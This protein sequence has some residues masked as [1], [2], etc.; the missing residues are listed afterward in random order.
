MG[1]STMGLDIVAVGGDQAQDGLR[2]LLARDEP[3]RDHHAAAVGRGAASAAAHAQGHDGRRR[4]DQARPTMGEVSD[5]PLFIDDSPNMSLMEIRAKCRRLKQRARPQARRHRLPAA[6]ELAA[7]AS[8]PA[9]RRSRSSPAR[10]SCWPRSSRCPVIAISPAQ[11]WPRAA[12]RQAAADVRPARVGLPDRRHPGP[13]RRH[14]RRGRRSASCMRV[15]RARRAGLGARRGLRYVAAHLTH[16]FPSGVKQVFRLTLASGK[17]VRATANHP[18]L[19]YDG[20]T[21][22]GELAAGSRLAV[23][24][25]VPRPELRGRWDDDEVVLLAHLLGDGS[26]VRAA[27]DPLRAASTRRTSRRSPRRPPTLRD[28]GGARRLRRG[29]GDH[30]APAGAVPARRTAGG[31]RSPRGSTAWGCSACAATRSSCPTRSS[32]CRRSRSRS[33]CA[34]SGRPTAPSRCDKDGRG[35]R[36]YYA[37]TSRAARRRRGAAAAAL[38]H[39]VPRAD[40]RARPATATATRLDI[41][42]ARRP[43]PVPRG[44][45]RPRRARRRRPTGCSRSCATTTAEHQRRH[46]AAAGLGRRAGGPRRAAA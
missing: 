13:A 32:A 38:R 10:S 11:P 31:T 40:D 35:G 16:V 21:P 29:P 9:S 41:S 17:Q 34:T 27:A 6:D 45:R 15:G 39:L 33:S 18:F 42:G 25:H 12:H 1:K 37:S 20:W 23:P 30:A 22:L 5:A 46:R 7:S 14:R 8:S 44:D 26:F 19:T 24:R 43:A 3:H 2:R 28:H 36:I 4:L